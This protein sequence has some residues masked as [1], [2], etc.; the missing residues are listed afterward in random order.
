MIRFLLS[1]VISIFACSTLYSS[2]KPMLVWGS[3]GEGINFQ[4][5]DSSF[6]V[7]MRVRFQTQANGQFIPEPDP[8][9]L[10]TAAFIRRM[11]L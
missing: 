3:F 5:K 6:S 9:N 4:P 7:K 2:D 1:I 8:R 10:R 11:R